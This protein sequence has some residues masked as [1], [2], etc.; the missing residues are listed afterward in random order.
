MGLRLVGRRGGLGDAES[1]DFD[2]GIS[3]GTGGDAFQ[4]AGVLA[5]VDPVVPMDGTVH[6]GVDVP[7][8]L[9]LIGRLYYQALLLVAVLVAIA[10][11]RRRGSPEGSPHLETVF[12]MSRYS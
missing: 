12:D 1:G 8:A 6:G 4:V 5:D 11:P 9:P 10:L 2:V 7:G 3:T